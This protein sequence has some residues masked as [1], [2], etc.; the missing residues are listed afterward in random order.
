MLVACL[1]LMRNSF[2]SPLLFALVAVH[3]VVAGTE[4]SA[5]PAPPQL[6]PLTVTVSDEVGAVIPKAL[7]TIRGE[8]PPEQN[9]KPSLLELRTD[10][11]GQ[12]RAGLP[13]GFYDVFV[14]L[15]GFA[16][17]ARKV[18]VSEGQPAALSFALEL[19]ERWAKE[20]GEEFPADPAG[21]F[22]GKA[23]RTSDGAQIHYIEVGETSR[24]PILLI[25]G[26]TMPA[27]IWRPQ[28][29]GLGRKY[30][31]VA[32]DP[33]SQGES[34]T[35]SD[36]NYPERRSRDFEELMDHLQLR[37]VTMVGWSMGVPETL[38]Y[39]NQFG[40][41]R[42]RALIL[43][44]GFVALDPKDSQLQAAFA[45]MLKQAELDHRRKKS[46]Y[47]PDVSV[48]FTY[49]TLR[50][51]DE[52]IPKQFASLGV[53]MKWEVFDWG[54]K[55][56]QLAEK[57]KTIEQARNELHETESEVLIDVG[58]KFRKLQQTR[59]ALVVA[60]LSQETAREALRVN[61]NRYRL[62]AALLSDVL[63]SQ[64]SL[65]DANHSYQQAILGYWTAKA[66]LE[67]AIG[68]GN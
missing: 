62:T 19:D 59:Q 41:S 15:S 66:E 18:R 63:Q 8:T 4:Q 10:S 36:G 14:A 34:D 22:T 33:R 65:A 32:V 45:G 21:V 52:V 26:W 56:D 11:E 1:N 54:R 40:T 35:P 17:R 28:L 29:E 43:V 51:F 44:D 48:G 12:A 67:K 58:D 60:Q 68:E 5:P 57:D 53:V 3:S 46:E 20:H 61:T 49:V 39:A 13:A 50:N 25:P 24:P 27:S 23:F 9:T 47:I 38:V 2:S 7:V 6:S 16:P 42:L 55:R 30:H 37:D 64:A 31:V